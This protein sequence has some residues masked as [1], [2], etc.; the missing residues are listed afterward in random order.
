M[1]RMRE[2]GKKKK[3]DKGKETVGVRKWVVKF[4]MKEVGKKDGKTYEEI[5]KKK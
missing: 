4:R 1:E 5:K 2:G 3:N